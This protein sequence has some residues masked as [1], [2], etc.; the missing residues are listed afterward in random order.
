ML[1]NAPIR[2]S[3][4]WSRRRLRPE[5]G[6]WRRD[7]LSG[8]AMSTVK[9]K[10]LPAR[11]GAL[12]MPLILSLF[13]TAIVS[14]VATVKTAGL[15]DNLLPL[16]LGAWEISLLIAFPTLLIVLPIVRRIVGFFVEP[17]SPQR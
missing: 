6:G 14:F 12:L 11:Y 2:G 3:L 16:W 10:R 5:C 17:H 9:L 4:A 13:M 8:G 7:L 1:G 15:A